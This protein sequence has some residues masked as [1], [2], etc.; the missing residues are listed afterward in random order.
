[1]KKIIFAII[2]L[3]LLSGCEEKTHDTYEKNESTINDVYK[4]SKNVVNEAYKKSKDTMD[5]SYEKSIQAMNDAY[6]KSKDTMSKSTKNMVKDLKDFTD[7]NMQ[8]IPLDTIVSKIA[9]VGIPA[10]VIVGIA[11]TSGLV[12]GAAI[13]GAISTVSGGAGLI[14][15]VVALGLIAV[16]GQAITVYGSEAVIKE[17]VKQLKEQGK[18]DDE[19]RET[20]QGYPISTSLKND[21]FMLLDK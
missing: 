3:V 1:M 20:I 16:A 10:L 9:G 11:S 6:E 13:V 19:I 18:T 12:G 8:K 15:G 2:V 14:P 5:N 4:K 21:V 17:V 7:K